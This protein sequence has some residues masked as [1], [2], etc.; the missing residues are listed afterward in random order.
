MAVHCGTCR[1]E[2]AVPAD[3]VF[4][5]TTYSAGSNI[6]L[7]DT[8]FSLTKANVTGALGYTPP[9]Q[10]TTYSAAT[11]SVD[12]LMSSTDKSKLDGI[13]SSYDSATETLT[14]NL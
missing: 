11:T 13:S 7:N 10:D 5:D 3:A 14:I 4:T 12:G 8:E 2:L 9:E 1:F 6:T